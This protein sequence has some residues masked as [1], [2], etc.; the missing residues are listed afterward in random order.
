MFR[1]KIVF[2]SGFKI[3]DQINILAVSHLQ[4]IQYKTINKKGNEQFLG[5]SRK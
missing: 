5:S 1:F 3:A 2:L 4:D